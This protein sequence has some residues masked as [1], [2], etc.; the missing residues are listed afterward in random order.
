MRRGPA[1]AALAGLFALGV[2]SGGL[3]AHL[4]YARALARP[5]GPPPFLGRFAAPPLERHLDL[6]AEQ[7]RAVRRILDES[8]REAE[9]L[10]RD[11][12]PR[13]RDVMERSQER[14][15]EQ[16][17]PEQRERFDELRRRHYRR[18]ER[19]FGRPEGRRPPPPDR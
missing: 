1:L 13:L 11:L 4:Y 12:A 9:D 17:T 5:P 16:L 15:R 19:F 14:I 8:R 2:V 18:S 7:R 3:G 6:T 10:R